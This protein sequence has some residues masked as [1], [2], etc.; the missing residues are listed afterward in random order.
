M[1]RSQLRD[2]RRPG[3]DIARLEKN[4]RTLDYEATVDQVIMDVRIAFYDI[5]RNQ[6]DVAV[7]EQ[8]VNFLTE[9]VKNEPARLDVGTGQKLNVLRAEV[10]RALEQSAL[11]DA[12]NRLRNSY[13]QLSQLLSLPYSIGDD[14][15]L[16][17][18][19]GTLVYQKTTLELDDCL[20]RALVQRPE[21]IA[22]EN[23]IK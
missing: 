20:A 5:L 22:R 3:M 7:H 10:N 9:Q 19:D 15:A 11:I 16:F 1:A 23:D 18:I 21:L 8:A 14:R 6:S 4:S 17:D 12:R 2:R 13:L